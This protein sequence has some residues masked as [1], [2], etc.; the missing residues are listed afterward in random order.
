MEDLCISTIPLNIHN[1]FPP[2]SLMH[3]QAQ[4]LW[5][6]K[7]DPTN[8]ISLLDCQI[9]NHYFFLFS[10]VFSSQDWI[11]HVN[12]VNHTAS[13][14][15]LRNKWV[16]TFF[17]ITL[18]WQLKSLCLLKHPSAPIK[19]IKSMIYD[20]RYH[21]FLVVWAV[22]IHHIRLCQPSASVIVGRAT[23]VFIRP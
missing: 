11:D 8:H 7:C 3:T 20:I 19:H 13:C 4:A 2:L 15:D 12:T 6:C 17:L 21:F 1:T 14:R 23:E 18:C 9:S 10:F 16:F 5:W 22:S